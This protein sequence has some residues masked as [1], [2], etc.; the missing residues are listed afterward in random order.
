MIGATMTCSR[1]RQP[2]ARKRDTV[3]APP[4]IRMRRKPRSASAARIAAGAMLPVVRGERARSRRRPASCVGAPARGD[5]QPA[6][7][8][9]RQHPRG[10]RQ[11]AARI[12]DDPRRAWARDAAH[13]QLRI[14][15]ER[16]ADADHHRVDQRAQPVQVGEAGRRR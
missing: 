12:D 9:V 7:A 16:R 15:G 3:S 8:V 5:H 1:S 14:V 2:A 6:D 4:S 10:R 11:A 13:R